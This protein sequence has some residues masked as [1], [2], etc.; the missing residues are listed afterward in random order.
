MIYVASPYSHP[1]KD[2]VE[3][4]VK[5][6]SQYSAKLLIDKQPSISPIT[7]GTTILKYTDLPSDFEFWQ[8]FSYDLLSVCTEIHILMLDGWRE[9]IGVQAEIAYAEEHNITITYIKP[10]NNE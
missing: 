2:V 8:Q 5:T 1:D 3:Y 7:V 10:Q 9:S 4:R 6:V